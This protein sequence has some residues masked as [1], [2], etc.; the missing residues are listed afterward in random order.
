MAMGQ[1]RS[2]SIEHV[3]YDLTVMDLPASHRELSMLPVG[4]KTRRD[5]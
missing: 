2:G 5:T 1:W 3:A 4:K